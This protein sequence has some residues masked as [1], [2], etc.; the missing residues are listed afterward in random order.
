MRL[1]PRTDGY[2]ADKVIRP[3]SA[4]WLGERARV[5]SPRVDDRRYSLSRVTKQACWT[6]DLIPTVLLYRVSLCKR[7]KPDPWQL[8]ICRRSMSL[9]FGAVMMFRPRQLSEGH[10]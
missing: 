4:V 6:V 7:H 5:L 1:P 9:E 3:E 8:G 2:E 10:Q